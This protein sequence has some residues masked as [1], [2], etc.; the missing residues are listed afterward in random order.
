MALVRCSKCGNQVSN[1]AKACPK[2]GF[3][4]EFT[5]KKIEK[6][7]EKERIRKR[8]KWIKIGVISGVIILL[9][10][11]AGILIRWKWNQ[12]NYPPEG[13]FRTTRWEMSKSE[14]EKKVSKKALIKENSIKEQYSN[15][16]GH[17]D[18][19]ATVTYRFRNDELRE[20]FVQVSSGQDCYNSY[21]EKF[22]KLYG[23]HEEYPSDLVWTTSQSKISLYLS[24]KND[25]LFITYADLFYPLSKGKWC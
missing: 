5:L 1:R 11:V 8:K 21:V 12:M 20:V 6:Q 18:V 15:Y 2:C 17:A 16:E 10:I 22:D 9:A 14:I 7:K 23:T 24:K 3:P 19:N 4:V 25:Q 13:Y